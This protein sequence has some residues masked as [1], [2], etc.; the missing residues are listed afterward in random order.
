LKHDVFLEKLVSVSRS[1][2]QLSGPKKQT[3]QACILRNDYMIDHPTNTIKLV[4]FNTIATGMG[5][6]SQKVS[7]LQK[8]IKDKYSDVIEYNYETIEEEEANGPVDFS[9]PK[10][11]D[12]TKNMI[13]YFNH[14]IELYKESVKS[15]FSHVVEDPWVL[16]VIEEVERNLTDQ[17]ILEV[18]LWRV[19]GVKSMRFSFAEIEKLSEMD[20]ETNILRIRGKEIGF[21]Y[22]RCGY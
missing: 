20:T 12:Y 9:G 8:Y 16:F 19:H 13:G 10:M 4:E 7:F 5:I 14:A 21:V 3:I 11:Q 18:E 22:Y 17:K 1:Y 15:K 6:L 2:N